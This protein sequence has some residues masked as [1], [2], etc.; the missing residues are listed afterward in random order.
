MKVLAAAHPCQHLLASVIIWIYIYIHSNGYSLVDCGSGLWSLS[1]FYRIHFWGRVLLCS[2]CW[3]RIVWPQTW[4]SP[5]SAFQALGLQIYTTMPSSFV[6]RLCLVTWTD[7]I[8]AVVE[9]TYISW[10][11]RLAIHDLKVQNTQYFP[12]QNFSGVAKIPQYGVQSKRAHCVCSAWVYV[13]VDSVCVLCYLQESLTLF[14]GS[15]SLIGLAFTSYT[16]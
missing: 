6:T 7:S 8:I 3:P 13:H 5:A 9:A 11:H 10:K 15:R 16:T 14:C 1:S 4:H 12:I 2:S